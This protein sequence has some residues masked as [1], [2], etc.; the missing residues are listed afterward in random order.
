LTSASVTTTSCGCCGAVLTVR[1]AIT[2]PLLMLQLVKLPPPVV[3]DDAPMPPPEG[4]I[5]G[6]EALRR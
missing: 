1:V 4:I 2:P 5:I 3:T 6:T